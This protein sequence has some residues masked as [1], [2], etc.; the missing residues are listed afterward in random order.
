MQQFEGYYW[1]PSRAPVFWFRFYT[2]MAAFKLH[3][4]IPNNYTFLKPGLEVK[5]AC[6]EAEKLG[7][8]LQFL[9]TEFDE[10][11]WSRLYHETRMNFPQ[12]LWKRLTY[13]GHAAWHKEKADLINRMSNCEPHQFTERCLDQ[14]LVNWYI[15]S[16]GVFFPRLKQIFIDKRD[17]D[18]FAQ[19]DRSSAKKI[20]VVCNQFHMEGIEHNWAHR[21]GQLPRSVHF[22]D[23]IDVI[24]D[25]DLRNGLFQRFYN[26]LH[27]EIN[28]ANS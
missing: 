20:V 9:G 6:E 25:M 13:N 15:Q 23:G 5:F 21:Y 11:T 8:N 27:R 2:Y 10:K 7:A 22:P 26:A 12:Y 24:G 4:R 16:M 14:Y 3:F 28:S 1:N 17:E 18:L 19:I